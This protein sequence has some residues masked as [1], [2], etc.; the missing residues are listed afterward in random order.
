MGDIVELEIRNLRDRYKLS[1]KL[2]QSF[3][4]ISSKQVKSFRSIN[5]KTYITDY[6]Y[7]NAWKTNGKKSKHQ[8]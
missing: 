7:G 4:N 6:F 1:K 8:L 2:G 3:F 5:A